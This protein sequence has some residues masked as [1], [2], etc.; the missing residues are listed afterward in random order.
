MKQTVSIRMMQ[1]LKEAVATLES[2]TADTM[3]RYLLSCRTPRGAFVGRN[4]RED[5]YY[6]TF[7]WLLS[8][9]MDI[10]PV[11]SE[12]DWLKAQPLEPADPV[13]AAAWVK[14][15]LL[16]ATRQHMPLLLVN[17]RRNKALVPNA[18]PEHPYATFLQLGMAE[19]LNRRVY[20]FKE[21]WLPLLDAHKTPDGGYSNVPGS[22]SFTT[23]ATAA[24]LVV[25][26]Q[27]LGYDPAAAQPLRAAQTESGG[28][29]ASSGAPVPDLLSTATALFALKQSGCRPRLDA[30]DFV[31]AH[32]HPD[33]TFVPT[34]LD[35]TGDVEYLFYGL[36]ALGSL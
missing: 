9:V 36:L 7:G 27:M 25:K 33:G 8:L 2:G 5:L 35:D 31:E 13:H 29:K 28:W 11:G 6:T 23:E 14:C 4:G 32:Y 15:H 21:K 12:A 3:R 26:G 19:D 34:L 17:L 24:A 1:T 18:Y 16:A 22:A 20:P 30:T 10:P